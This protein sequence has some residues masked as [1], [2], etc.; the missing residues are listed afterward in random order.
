MTANQEFE[1]RSALSLAFAMPFPRAVHG[2]L[3]AARQIQHV[4]SQINYF[5]PQISFFG[6]S[7]ASAN[8]QHSG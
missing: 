8:L 1:A 5:P 6:F 4:E 2:L 7:L 3:L